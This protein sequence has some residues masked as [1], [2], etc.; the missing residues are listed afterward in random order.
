[1]FKFVAI[2]LFVPSLALAQDKPK[3]CLADKAHVLPGHDVLVTGQYQGKDFAFKISVDGEPVK[4]PLAPKET[5]PAECS[6]TS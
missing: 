4:D 1:M 6:L 5:L 3:Q 2:L